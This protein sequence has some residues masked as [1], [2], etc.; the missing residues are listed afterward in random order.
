MNARDIGKTG[1]ISAGDKPP[2]YDGSLFVGADSISARGIGETNDISGR[3]G[4]APYHGISLIRRGGV[5]PPAVS[6]K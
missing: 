3:Q 4:A 5:S 1:D 2:P 6:V